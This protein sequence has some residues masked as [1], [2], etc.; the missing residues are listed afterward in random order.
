MPV[1]RLS[2]MDIEID[3]DSFFRRMIRDLSGLLQDVVGDDEARGF[4]A[5]VGARI[6]DLFN[7][8]YQ[9]MLGGRQLSRPEVSEAL[10]DLKTRIGGEF[11]VE[12]QSDDE[13]V[14]VNSRCPFAESVENRPSLCMMTS[15]VFGRIAAENLG[16]ARVSVEEAFATGHARC[17]VR[18][19][20]KQDHGGPVEVDAR[21]YYRTITPASD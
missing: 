21:E 3:R 8:T 1:T 16:Y 14:F 9:E 2:D 15:N 13:I 20:L 7:R 11:S 12:S 18:V 6:G 4:V 17:R 10:V 5:I 19:S